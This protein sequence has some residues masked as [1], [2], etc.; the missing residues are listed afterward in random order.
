MN[1]LEETC[2]EIINSGHS[3]EDIKFIGSLT[4]NHQCAWKKFKKLADIEYDNGYGYPE[5]VTDLV[6]VFSDSGILKRADYDGAESWMY[7]PPIPK[8]IEKKEINF[9]FSTEGW[10]TLSELNENESEV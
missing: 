8:G 9:I 5:V 6:I 2:E 10:E 4:S 7:I 1:L 3:I